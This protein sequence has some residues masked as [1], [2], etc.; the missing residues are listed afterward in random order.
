MFVLDSSNLTQH[1]MDKICEQTD[2]VFEKKDLDCEYML[3]I[4]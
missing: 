3:Y 2:E 1:D 4:V